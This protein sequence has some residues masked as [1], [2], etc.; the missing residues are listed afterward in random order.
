MGFYGKIKENGISVSDKYAGT[1]KYFYLTPQ[2]L[3]LLNAL[4]PMIPKYAK[5]KLLDAGAGRLAY[6]YLLE[7]CCNRYESIDISDRLSRVDFVG[8]IQNMQLDGGQY[9]T[10]FCSQV[11]EHVPEPQ[12]ALSEFQRILKDGGKLILTVPHLSYL[13]NEPHDYF[14]YT[15]HG[16]RFMLEKSG[17]KI[18]ILEPAG[19]II[20]F[21]GHLP[22]TIFVNSLYN[23]PLLHPLSMM[24]NRLYV[25]LIAWLD[26]NLEKQKV[27]ALNYVVVAQKP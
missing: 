25:K 13:H 4:K 23:I 19:G 24:I 8:D 2:G 11:L 14:R 3:T 22:S 27:Y 18:I 10:V 26:E 12:K 20:S 15:K 16:L 17:F 1:E 5:G 21:L 6:K 9:D 7:P